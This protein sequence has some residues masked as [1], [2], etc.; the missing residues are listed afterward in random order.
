MKQTTPFGIALVFSVIGLMMSGYLT[1]WNLWGP[2]CH[3]GPLSWL[4][5]CGG[6][7]KVLI[8]GLPTCVYG[9]FM[10]LTVGVTALVGMISKAPRGSIAT[11]LGLGLLGTAFSGGL[12]AY[13]LFILKLKFSSLPACAV[14]F[15]FFGGILI[16]AI[17]ARRFRAQ[18]PSATVPGSV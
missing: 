18:P 10:Y 12:T 9:F 1:Y 14:G 4:I 8:F 11:L 13:E 3:E 6:P 15:V 5:S 17:I 7:Q 2:G 16:S